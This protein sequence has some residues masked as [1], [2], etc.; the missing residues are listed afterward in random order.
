V[1]S[2]SVFQ[3]FNNFS[4]ANSTDLRSFWKH[5]LSAAVIARAIAEKMGYPHS[6]EAYLAGLLH[7]VGRLA[8]LATAPKEYAGSFRAMDDDALCASEQQ[9]LNITHQEAGAWLIKRWNL[10]S[11]LSDSV[12]YH[13]ESAARLENA[14]PLIRIVLLAH[15]MSDH[16]EDDPAVMAAGA[17]CGIH[18]ADL[19]TIRIGAISQVKQ[20]AD[21]LGIDL[22]EVSDAIDYPVGTPSSSQEPVHQQ[23]S[24]EVRNLVLTA[25]AGRSFSRQSGEAGLIEAIARSARLLFDFDDVAILLMDGTGQKLVGIPLGDHK[26]RLKEFSIV[27]SGGGLVVESALQR[28]LAYISS[29]GN[30]LGV[31]EEQL[32]RVIGSESLVC[33]PLANAKRCQGILIG[34]VAS[35]HVAALRLRERFMSS[36]GEQAAASLEAAFAD[37]SEVSRRAASVADEF[38]QAARKAVHEANNPLSIIKNYLGVLDAKL[39]RQQPIQGELSILNDEIDR[40]ARIIKDFPELKPSTRDGHTEVNRVVRDV[41]RLFRDTEYV[42]AAVKIFGQTQDQPT[43]IEVHADTLKQILINLVKNAIEAMPSGGEIKIMNCG[44]VNR[45]GRLYI[46]LR[47]ADSGPGIPAEVLEKIFTPL[48][49]TKGG[50]HQGLGLNIVH[51]LVKKS[52]GL[53][54]CRS[55]NMGAA[56][57]ILFPARRQTESELKS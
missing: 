56:F 52:D 38:K 10:D 9:M 36:F 46:E 34:G 23:L 41:V 40:V 39:E 44:Q 29:I 53:I 6:E 55:S 51:G 11:F 14:H 57:E 13:H 25:E 19:S 50:E 12:L 8:L 1:I 47:I 42:P 7:D 17:L 4:H 30:P 5:S 37:R 45:D 27:L 22:E 16:G 18:A 31:A 20:A 15:L 49:S 28:R 21:S 24:D 35:F 48:M 32:L 33:L 2:E 54:S 3:V 43:E 26:Q